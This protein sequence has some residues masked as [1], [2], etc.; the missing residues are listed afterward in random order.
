MNSNKTPQP[1]C[2]MVKTASKFSAG[3]IPAKYL[4]IVD[5]TPPCSADGGHPCQHI[6]SKYQGCASQEATETGKG[7]TRSRQQR[8]SFCCFLPQLSSTKK[9][10]VRSQHP[11]LSLGFAHIFPFPGNEPAG[12]IRKSPALLHIQAKLHKEPCHVFPPA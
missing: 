2:T 12:S 11:K 5:E 6:F 8:R 9:N 1:W 3:A 10:K 4:G 7:V